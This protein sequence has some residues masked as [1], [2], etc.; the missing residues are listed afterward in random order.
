MRCEELGIVLIVVVILQSRSTI[1]LWLY[2]YVQQVQQ[3]ALLIVKYY[4][5]QSYVYNPIFIVV[6]TVVTVVR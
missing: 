6:S 1:N 3:V 5:V 4:S 2:L